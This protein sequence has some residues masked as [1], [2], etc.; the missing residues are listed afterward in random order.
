MSCQKCNGTSFREDNPGELQCNTC[1]LLTFSK[2]QMRKV[3]TAFAGD[4]MMRA[5]Q[6]QRENF[7]EIGVANDSSLR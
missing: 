7:P 3:L 2:E 5:S 1:G 6:K 4:V